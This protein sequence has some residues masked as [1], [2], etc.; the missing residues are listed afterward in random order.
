MPDISICTP[1]YRAHPAPNLVTLAASLPAALDRIE[2]ELVVALNGISATRAGVPPFAITVDLGVNR[3]VAP[4]WNAAA[5]AARAD[6]LCFANDDVLP[7]AG[8]LR[9]LVEALRERPEAG[10]VGP[11]GTRWDIA[12]A[13]H[14]AWLPNDSGE[15][16]EVIPCEVVSGFLFAC[17]REVYDAVGGFDERYAP[18]SWE[19]VDFC[20]AVRARGLRCYQVTGVEHEHEFGVSSRQRPWRRARW[21]GRS[22][23][24]WWI[25]RRNR[26]RFMR[27]WRDAALPEQ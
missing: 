24:I 9:L 10:V 26:R 16:G 19:E 8:A 12:K 13:R 3:G 21:D 18:F 11:V 1:V 27:K 17:R 25:H 15:P 2:G 4:G 14:L 7:G 23:S 22:Q 6:V 20:T 5:R